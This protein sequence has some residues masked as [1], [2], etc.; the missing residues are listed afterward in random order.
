MRTFKDP[1]LQS[2]S[3]SRDNRYRTFDLVKMRAARENARA[4]WEAKCGFKD[5][6][7]KHLTT[8]LL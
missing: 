4:V 3:Q 2:K 1:E 8:I 7:Q 5:M 6:E